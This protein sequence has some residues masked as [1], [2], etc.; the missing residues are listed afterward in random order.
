LKKITKNNNQYIRNIAIKIKLIWDIIRS[1]KKLNNDT[2]IN[3]IKNIFSKEYIQYLNF[4]VFKK[5]NLNIT[6]V[7][8]GDIYIYENTMHEI[9]NQIDNILNKLKV[10]IF[11]H[12]KI[13]DL[14]VQINYELLMYKVIIINICKL[15]NKWFMNNNYRSI[16]EVEL[17]NIMY[18]IE[19]LHIK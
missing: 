12:I 18:D 1:N 5:K 15:I 13:D 19:L 3:T 10:T 9:K 17:S 8:Y 14:L 4:L 6:N 16:K 7:E 11:G 2:Y